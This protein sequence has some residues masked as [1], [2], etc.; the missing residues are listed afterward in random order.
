[1]PDD[2]I[3]DPETVDEDGTIIVEVD[4]TANTYTVSLRGSVYD[5]YQTVPCQT[6]LD[7]KV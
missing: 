1:M 7:Q 2:R 6:L 4:N 3:G 5:T